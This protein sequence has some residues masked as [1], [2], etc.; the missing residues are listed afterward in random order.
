MRYT[1]LNIY[2]KYGGT[3]EQGCHEFLICLKGGV[4]TPLYIEFDR[5]LKRL[6]VKYTSNIW[7]RKDRGVK[8]Q[9][10]FPRGA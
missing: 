5:F 9:Q 7:K 4:N 10:I 6:L 1:I 2:E 3:P 8:V